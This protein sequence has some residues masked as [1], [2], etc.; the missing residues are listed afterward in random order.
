MNSPFKILDSAKAFGE[1]VQ[2]AA[3]KKAEDSSDDDWGPAKS[4]KPVS[5]Q[6]A[7]QPKKIVAP[8]KAA[9]QA[10]DLLSFDSTPQKA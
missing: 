3:K 8:G 4:K 1:A 9:A 2:K 5:K 10:P 6:V 7:G